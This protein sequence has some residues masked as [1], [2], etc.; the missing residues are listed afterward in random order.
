MCACIVFNATGNEV[1]KGCFGSKFYV[2]QDGYTNL[3]CIGNGCDNLN[4]YSK[5][6]LK[7]IKKNIS[8]IG[9]G[10]CKV[11]ENCIGDWK[12][13]CDT[14]YSTITSFSGMICD[15]DDCD[16]NDLK[17]LIQKSWNLNKL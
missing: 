4:I 12:L 3:E 17:Q 2:P 1:K 11:T 5:N 13:Y 8:I 9:C 16:C 15:S 14:S 10:E 7:N 6:G